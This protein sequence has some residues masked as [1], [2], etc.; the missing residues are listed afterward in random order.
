[1]YACPASHPHDAEGLYDCNSGHYCCDT[2]GGE[3]GSGHSCNGNAG[4][5]STVPKITVGRR[6][7][8]SQTWIVV[9]VD[10][11][12][13]GFAAPPVIKATL[14]GDDCQWVADG[15]GEVYAATKSG[16]Q[17]RVTLNNGGPMNAHHATCRG[18]DFLAHAKNGWHVMWTA[19]PATTPPPPPPPPPPVIRGGC[20]DG[21]VR[22]V[23]TAGN[24][25][26]AWNKPMIPEVFHSGGWHPICG[27]GF[28][29]NDNGATTLCK[30]LG[31]ASGTLTRTNATYSKNAVPVGSC[32]AG[33]PF[34]KCTGKC[35]GS[36]TPGCWNHWGN[37]QA[38][39]GGC[40]TK[41]SVSVAVTCTG[42]SMQRTSSCDGTAHYFPCCCLML[43]WMP[44]CPPVFKQCT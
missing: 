27:H 39:D 16:F 5:C 18:Y 22:T 33:E 30:R 34:T 31:F 26:S 44:A 42:G 19:A 17:L 13:C 28:W 25:T 8:T 9:D 24:P 1:M 29:D 35:P 14:A 41:Y 36:D 3:R 32:N 11:S 20:I 43:S 21:N 40:T 4:A 37:F 2:T 15:G 6:G 38:G 10:T 12:V 23:D 7:G